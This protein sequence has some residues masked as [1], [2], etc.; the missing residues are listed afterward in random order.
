MDRILS[1]F[2]EAR[3]LTVLFWLMVSVL[4]VVKVECSAQELSGLVEYTDFGKNSV[5]VS[6]VSEVFPKNTEEVLNV[7]RKAISEKRS[8]RVRA[9]A[10]SMNGTT[11]PKNDEILLRTDSLS[12]FSFDAEGTITVGCGNRIHDILPVLKAHGFNLPAIPGGGTG[13]TVGGFIAAGGFDRNLESWRFHYGGFWENVRSVKIVTGTGD[14]LTAINGDT[15]FSYLFG[16]M[17]QLGIMISATLDIV[18]DPEQRSTDSAYPLGLRGRLV[19]GSFEQVYPRDNDV[20]FGYQFESMFWYALF[21]P[22]SENDRVKGGLAHLMAYHKGRSTSDVQYNIKCIPVPFRTFM[23][24]LVYPLQES[25]NGCAMQ[26]FHRKRSVD[27]TSL[28]HDMYELADSL[29]KTL[30]FARYLQGEY[31]PKGPDWYKAYFG[32]SLYESFRKLRQKMDPNE[33]I[34]PGTVFPN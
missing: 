33:I 23:P 17:G 14:V 9:S 27:E 3:C 5:S 11:L 8:I 32:E 18:P 1:S 4:T 10:H 25:F 2:L 12:Q 6:G 16:G 30:G 34:N 7:V 22:D 13:I 31:V 21:G 28:M 19:R 24:P 26:V 20:L 29:G 15:L